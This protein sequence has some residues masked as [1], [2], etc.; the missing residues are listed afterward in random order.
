MIELFFTPGDEEV[1]WVEAALKEMVVGY[2]RVEL[3][4]EDAESTLGKQVDLPAIRHDERLISGREGLLA[5]LNELERL[6]EDWRRF[7]ADACY[8]EENGDVC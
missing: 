2:E 5:Y 6:V 3:A 1:V 4:P 7:Q 8:I